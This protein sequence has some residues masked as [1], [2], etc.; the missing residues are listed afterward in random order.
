MQ[1]KGLNHVVVFVDLK[2][3]FDKVRYND[4]FHLLQTLEVPKDVLD[5]LWKIYEND[6][7]RYRINNTTTE[8]IENQK[9]VKQGASSSPILFNLII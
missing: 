5:I 6:Q 4:I 2:K 8:N 7:T 9:G 1:A 3:A